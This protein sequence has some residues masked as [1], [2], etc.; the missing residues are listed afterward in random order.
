VGEGATYGPHPDASTHKARF[1]AFEGATHVREGSTQRGGRDG[2]KALGGRRRVRGV[3]WEALGGT[4]KRS[5]RGADAELVRGEGAMMDSNPD[6]STH[7]ARFAAFEGATQFREGSTQRGGGDAWKALGGR[8]RVEEVGW[9]ALG[10]TFKRSDRAA[11]AELVRGEGAMMDPNPNASTHKARFAAFEGATQLREGSTQ[12][13]GGDGWKTLG[14]T[15]KRSGRVADAELVRSSGDTLLNHDPR[16]G[17][18]SMHARLQLA[19]CERT[20]R[21]KGEVARPREPVVSNSF[22]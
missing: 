9:E 15:R 11:D 22:H 7:K 6:A 2:W 14:G 3:G 21:K 4:F 19:P 5:G 16:H 12:R 17:S 13:G 10:G 8:R 18:E 1:A 20:A